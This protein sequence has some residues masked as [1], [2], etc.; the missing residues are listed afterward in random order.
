MRLALPFAAIC[1]LLPP[2][3]RAAE[4]RT[5]PF[6][7]A[8]LRVEFDETVPAPL[9]PLLLEW[10][11]QSAQAVAG[12][13]GKF[14]V[15]RPQLFLRTRSGRGV[16]GGYADG[17]NGARARISVGRD[18]TRADLL[19]EDWMLTHELIHLGFP[20][21]PDRHHWIEEGL[22]SYVEPIARVRA[23]VLTP[24]RMWADFV[25]GMPQGQP[26]ANDRGL[27]FTPTWGRTYW[28]GALFCLLW[29]VEI[30]QQSKNQ[31]GLEDALRA[32]VAAGGNIERSWSMQRVISVADSATGT[33][34]LRDLYER[35]SATAVTVDLEA[36]WRSLGVQRR[37]RRSVEFDEAAPLAPV[38][39]AIESG[40]AGR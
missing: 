21:V 10:I 5:L 7:G 13:Y 29:D 11:T 37:S 28:G 39:R 15:P 25:A 40:K 35:H 32:I 23:G 17:W 20:S 12:Y 26:E 9:Q 16:S 31:R 6:P 30:R 33:T 22:A 2:L 34:A 18:S 1:L 4:T 19:E 3:S 27:D 38:R 8:E 24:Q 14:P 36:L